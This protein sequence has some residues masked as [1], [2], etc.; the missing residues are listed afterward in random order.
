VAILDLDGLI[1]GERLKSCSD[2][3]RWAFPYFF[4]ASN[5][6]A[7]LELD[8]DRLKDIFKNFNKPVSE[9]QIAEFISEYKQTYLLFTYAAAD[10]SFWGQWDTKW[11]PTYQKEC[12]KR[13]PQ[14]NEVEFQKWQEEYAERKRQCNSGKKF[15]DILSQISMSP[16]ANGHANGQA[17]E[18]DPQL[19]KIDAALDVVQDYYVEKMDRSPKTWKFTPKRKQLGRKRFRECLNDVGGDFEKA[20]ALMKLAID[21]TAKNDYLMGRDPKSHGKTFNEWESNIFKSYEQMEQR[22]NAAG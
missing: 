4:T 11:L 17:E 12:D 20:V 1:N 3:A 2:G 8:L 7:R 10:G 19:A 14:P 6:C 15:A 21:G 9:E 18:A 5:T 22:R 16:R 13:T